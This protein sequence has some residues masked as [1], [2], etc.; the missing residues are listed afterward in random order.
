MSYAFRV[1]A[2]SEYV[3]GERTAGRAPISWL[4]RKGKTTVLRPTSAN[5]SNLQ[6]SPDGRRLALEIVDGQDDIWVYE[7]ERDVLTRLTSDPASD[8]NPVWTPDGH[9]I[10]FASTRA[11][12]STPN[13]YWQQADGTGEVQRLTE[14][15]NL[16]LPASWHPD[17]HVLAFEEQNPRTG[18]DLML[19][20]LT[21]DDVSGWKPGAPTV[22]LNSLF[23][24]RQ[25]TFSRDGHW[26]AYSSNET[27]RMEVYVRPFPG[28]GGKWQISTDGGDFPVWSGAKHELFYR[29]D[30]VD[31][32]MVAPFV[33]KGDSFRAEKPSPWLEARIE[34]RGS[35]RMFD[36]HPDGERL[37]LRPAEQRTDGAKHDHVTF[38][39][40]FF[41]ELR[42]IAPD[43]KR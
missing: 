18:Y 40:N 7:W 26:L 15:K 9:R 43:T 37:A 35:N 13:L 27:G 19:L 29:A 3:P 20:P 10:A 39:F 8:R 17:G 25:P 14:S 28:P 22:F 1:T 31:Q 6:F 32:I 42:R 33:V 34:R 12:A 5:W 24:E 11:D 16:Q 38:I 30:R 41:D 23:S 21:G 36:V 4:D 2:F